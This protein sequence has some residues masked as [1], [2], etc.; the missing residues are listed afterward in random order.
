[1][2]PAMARARQRKNEQRDGLGSPS[3]LTAPGK[4]ESAGLL[5]GAAPG[6]L[7]DG[8]PGDEVSPGQ[9]EEACRCPEIGNEGGD[10]GRRD[11]RQADNEQ[12]QT[13]LLDQLAAA[14]LA[15]WRC[16][17]RLNSSNLNLRSAALVIGR[18]YHAMRVVMPFAPT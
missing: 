3:S 13:T 15:C 10:G 1:M 11:H 17:E 8:R 2:K 5:A 9:S 14:R 18:L 16:H 4:L 6:S 12:P 7:A